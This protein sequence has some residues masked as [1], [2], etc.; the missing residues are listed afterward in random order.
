MSHQVLEIN[1]AVVV[2]RVIEGE[3]L[4]INMTT[5][6]YYSLDGTGGLIWELL[7]NGPCSASTLAAAL[8]SVFTAETSQIETEINVLLNELKTEGLL[9]PAEKAVD[10]V[11][12][13][14]DIPQPFT[15]PVLM[16]YTDLEALLLIDPI[17]DVS[18]EGWPHTKS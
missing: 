18:P 2:C 13:V 9:T 14:R 16:K 17:H 4:I 12:I 6:S 7:Q 10:L 11:Q 15:P 1:H 5:G 8:Q 3:A